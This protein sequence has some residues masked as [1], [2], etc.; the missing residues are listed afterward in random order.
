MESR[1]R[2]LHNGSKTMTTIRIEATATI[3]SAIIVLLSLAGLQVSSGGEPEKKVGAGATI[4]TLQQAIENRFGRPDRIVGEGNSLLQYR[5][6][7]EDTLTIILA[8]EKVV[9]IEHAKKT[10]LKK[11]V[12]KNVTLVGVYNGLAKASDQIV[13]ADGQWF[14]LE[15]RHKESD[16]GKIAFVTGVL[17]YFPGTDDLAHAQIG[18]VPQGIPSHYYMESDSAEIKFLYPFKFVKRP[19][20]ESSRPGKSQGSADPFE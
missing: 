5:L 19:P 10:D 9:G 6:E 4:P 15:N 1:F 12:G 18:P 7:N 17:K 16:D 13:L 20:I 14:W 8:N 11:V 3:L 2:F